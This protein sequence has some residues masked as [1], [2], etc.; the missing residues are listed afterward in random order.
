MVLSHGQTPVGY[1][2]LFLDTPIGP[3]I[4]LYAV[5]G[6]KGYVSMDTRRHPIWSDPD[7]LKQTDWDPFP[8]R[9][10]DRMAGRW[11]QT[12]HLHSI[13]HRE[14]RAVFGPDICLL[15]GDQ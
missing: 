14:E 5:A 3:S 8:I 9:L 6:V 4:A 15:N 13:A 12:V 11:K 7:R 1:A 2:C 10:E